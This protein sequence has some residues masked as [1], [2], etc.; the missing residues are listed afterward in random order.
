M[1]ISF[2][3]QDYYWIEWAD[4]HDKNNLPKFNEAWVKSGIRI[5]NFSPGGS[6]SF[7]YGSTLNIRS[8]SRNVTNNTSDNMITKLGNLL[9]KRCNRTMKYYFFDLTDL[10]PWVKCITLGQDTAPSLTHTSHPPYSQGRS[11]TKKSLKN[12]CLLQS[13]F[14]ELYLLLFTLLYSNNST[15]YPR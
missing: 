5:Q 14:R 7:K 4:G 13:D 9:S 10:N 15:K 12:M 8:L 2:R 11:I 1:N 3:G 6:R